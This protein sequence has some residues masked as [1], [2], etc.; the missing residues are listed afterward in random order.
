[1]DWATFLEN[2]SQSLFTLG[3]VF[4]GSLITFLI[5]YLNNIFQSKEREKDRED[6]RREGRI[7]AKEKWIE[8]DILKIM[9]LVEYIITITSEVQSYGIRIEL[10]ASR[11]KHHSLSDDEFNKEFKSLLDR[12]PVQLYEGDRTFARIDELVYSFEE[13]EI[14]SSYK[15]FRGARNDYWKQ[16]SENFASR[17]EELASES[18]E[19]IDTRDSR[20]KMVESAGKFQMALRN[21][22]IALRDD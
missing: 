14:N 7:Q 21:K 10:I 8:R 2:N 4:L 19:Q 18:A 1:M 16:V 5:S 6:K 22:L 9:D 17:I 13:P 15:D 12:I 3:G 11:K 20:R